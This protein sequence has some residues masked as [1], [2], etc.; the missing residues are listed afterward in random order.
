MSKKVGWVPSQPGRYGEYTNLY[1][2]PVQP[3][4]TS[5][6]RDR[7]TIFGQGSQC[8]GQDSHQVLQIIIDPPT[9]IYV[10]HD[11]LISGLF[12]RRPEQCTGTDG[13]GR[14]RGPVR[15]TYHSGELLEGLR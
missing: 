14:V 11:G 10:Q 9:T 1:V 15:G 3:P 8:L 6:Y 12:A 4:T 13:E 2:S 7:R 5:D